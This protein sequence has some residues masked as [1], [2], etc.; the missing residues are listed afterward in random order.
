MN[1]FRYDWIVIIALL[2]NPSDSFPVSPLPFPLYPIRSNKDPYSMLLSIPPVSFINYTVNPFKLAIFMSFFISKITLIQI[3]VSPLHFSFAIN[4]VWFLNTCF[5]YVNQKYNY[6]WQVYRLAYEMCERQSN[7]LF[8][9][10]ISFFMT[11]VLLV[12]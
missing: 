4:F 11:R 7:H 1:V 9:V 5:K 8:S 6:L 10:M 2:L 12:D 3:A